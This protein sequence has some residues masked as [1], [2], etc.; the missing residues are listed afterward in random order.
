MK[1]NINVQKLYLDVPDDKARL[2]NFL[3]AKNFM[4]VNISPNKVINNKLK[5][6]PSI[7]D[8]NDKNNKIAQQSLFISNTVGQ[9]KERYKQIN[10]NFK[11]YMNF[12]DYNPVY[13]IDPKKE[14]HKKKLLKE[15]EARKQ[16]SYPKFNINFSSFKTEV[17]PPILDK[18]K[19]NNKRNKPEI[20]ETGLEF[21]PMARSL[22]ASTSC[23]KF[24]TISTDIGV[25]ET[26]KVYNKEFIYHKSDLNHLIPD[27][28]NNEFAKNL[29]IFQINAGYR[30]NKRKPFNF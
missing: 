20:F 17:S 4:S 1:N 3:R 26:G 9:E 8:I 12:G 30:K 7:Q 25:K 21:N 16:I 29:E 15:R 13:S 28:A 22:D 2:I 14:Y 10:I 11:E 23:H 27:V 6:D 24:A 19:E 18:R 5:E